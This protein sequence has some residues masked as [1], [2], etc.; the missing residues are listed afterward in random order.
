MQES[1]AP[2]SYYMIS[3]LTLV[4]IIVVEP[5]YSFLFDSSLEYIVK[6]QASATPLAKSIWKGY[7]NFGIVIVL[8]APIVFSIIKFYERCRA[9]YYVVMLTAMLF[10]MNVT[11]LCYW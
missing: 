11:K 9:F 8:A 4:L 3:L 6:V 10:V 2:T 7:S 1:H 5:S